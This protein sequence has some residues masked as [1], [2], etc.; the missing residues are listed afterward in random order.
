[1]EVIY[2]FIVIIVIWIVILIITNK[3]RVNVCPFCLS[4]DFDMREC[5]NDEILDENFVCNSCKKIFDEPISIK[6]RNN[7]AF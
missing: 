4:K 1:M 7:N 2:I 6:K 3:T 5:E